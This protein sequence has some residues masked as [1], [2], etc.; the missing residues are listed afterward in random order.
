M[1]ISKIKAELQEIADLY[2]LKL[3]T[4]DFQVIARIA[5]INKKISQCNSEGQR[6]ELM[7]Q[8]RIVINNYR[9]KK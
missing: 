4:G 6:A 2:G 5:R 8:K 1:K 3:N 9:E 7:A